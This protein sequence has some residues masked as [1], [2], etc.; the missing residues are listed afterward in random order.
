V[1]GECDGSYVATG[2]ACADAEQMYYACCIEE[3]F[4]SCDS[5][6][7][8][9]TCWAACL[10]ASSCAELRAAVV[11]GTPSDTLLACMSVCAEAVDQFTCDDGTETIPMD[12]VCDGEPDCSDGSDELPDYCAP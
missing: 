12:W 2:D 4:G 5:T 11:T 3:D 1:P 7:Q 10:L 8:L 6:S 9:E